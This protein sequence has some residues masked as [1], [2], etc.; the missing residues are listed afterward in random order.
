MPRMDAAVRAQLIGVL[1]GSTLFGALPAPALEA[2]LPHLELCSLQGGERL[3]AQGDAADALY[4]LRSGRLGVFDAAAPHAG[5]PLLLGVIG[6]GETIGEIGALAGRARPWTVRALRDCTLLRLPAARLQDLMRRHPELA[7][8]AAQHALARGL[9]RDAESPSRPP[10]GFALLPY[11][12]GIDARAV[13]QRLAEALRVHGAS[14]VLDAA[15]AQGR[16]A[17]WFD[18]REREYRFLLYVADAGDSDWRA[19]CVRQCDQPLLLVSARTAPA[20]WPDV[21][22]RSARDALNRPRHLLIAGAQGAPAAGL[23]RAWLGAFH[24]PPRAHHLRGEADYARLARVLARRE[25]ALV[26][27]GGGARGFAHIGVVKALRALGRPIDHVGG[28]SIGA[29]VAAGV[30][31][32]WDDAEL[33]ARMHAAF[34]AGRPLRDLTLPLVALTRG[35]RTTRLLREAFGER[36]I[37]DLALPFFCVS[38]N[39]TSGRVSVHTQGPLWLWLRASAA[40][41]GI[42]PPLLRDGAVHVDGAVMN[43]LP[44]DVMRARCSGPLTAVDISGDDALGAGF[45]GTDLPRLPRLTWHWAR[46]RRWPSLFSILVRSAMVYSETAS[47][48]HRALADHLLTPPH[49]NIGLLD[50]AACEQAIEAGYRDTLAHFESAAGAGG[51]TSANASAA[52]TVLPA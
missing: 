24:E 38:S 13:A 26:L 9:Q 50:W 49:A 44:T 6:P 18:A 19:T 34:V 8:R 17:G 39:L 33:H 29:I 2:L 42:L 11:D 7:L 47:A 10:Q 36:A 52:G 35:A 37:E 28:T 31:C 32:E 48:R 25:A 14:L 1:Q 23:A 30:A 15:Q 4:L 46:G 22:C 43:N 20:A 41:P 12:A 21:A 27:S 16:P 40:I 45:N 51:G 5:A 3:Y